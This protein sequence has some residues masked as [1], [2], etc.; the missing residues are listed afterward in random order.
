MPRAI[1]QYVELARSFYASRNNKSTCKFI[2]KRGQ[3]YSIPFLLR[4]AAL[5]VFDLLKT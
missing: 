4:D 2:A 1:F 5:P 3:N